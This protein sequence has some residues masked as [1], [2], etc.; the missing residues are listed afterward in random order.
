MHTRC[1]PAALGSLL[2][3]VSLGVRAS[4]AE[5][6]PTPEAR[7]HFRAGLEHMDANRN[8][9]AYREFKAA[10][11]MS[12]KAKVLV[13]LG[14]VAERLERDGEAIDAYQG[15][16]DGA[17]LIARE[18]GAVQRSLERLRGRIASVT[19]EAPG[20]FSVTDTRTDAAAGAVVNQYGPFTGRAELRVRA[21]QHE[22]TVNGTSVEAPAWNVTLLAGDV[23]RHAFERE[24]GLAVLKSVDVAPPIAPSPAQDT[25]PPSH[26]ASYVLWGAGGLGA[27]ATVV[28]VLYAESVQDEANDDFD[29][30]CP[31][32]GGFGECETR[33][34]QA[35]ANWRTAGLLTGIGAFGALAT[36]TVLY[37]WNSGGANEDEHVSEASVQPWVSPTGIGI[38][39]TF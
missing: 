7:A 14:I 1:F 21:G 36:G 29:S 17:A 5:P 16:H 27:A 6:E 13:N 10:Y 18:S 32:G 3:V 8:I 39:G 33:G 22:F 11:A 35:A 26:A 9:E 34:S 20:T 19:L 4:A 30:R 15:Y 23:V 25:P 28:V 12:L 24:P 2:L 38:S 31:K 37:F